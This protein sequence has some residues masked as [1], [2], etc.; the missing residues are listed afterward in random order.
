MDCVVEVAPEDPE[1]FR[2]YIISI[3]LLDT[4]STLRIPSFITKL[5]LV[6]PWK[7]DIS[8]FFDNLFQA[9][10]SIPSVIEL[11]ANLRVLQ[12]LGRTSGSESLLPR[13][14]TISLSIGYTY[15]GFEK[16][17]L[18]FFVQRSNIIPIKNLRIECNELDICDLRFLDAMVGLKVSWV[19]G[20]GIVEYV[21]GSGNKDR[22]I[23]THF[24]G[25]RR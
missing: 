4:I 13:L 19:E 8:D 12:H 14:E 18:P 15:G 10:K 22:L 9:L 21:C 23:L 20:R 7:Q 5:E 2:A 17:I 11:V 6:L 25:L 3:R 16:Y 1:D 24:A